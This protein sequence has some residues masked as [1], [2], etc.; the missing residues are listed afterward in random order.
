MEYF[1]FL[2]LFILFLLRFANIRRAH[3]R[4]NTNSSVP[5]SACIHKITIELLNK[6]LLNLMFVTLINIC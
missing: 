5:P 3:V 4:A 6:F 2:V 1:T